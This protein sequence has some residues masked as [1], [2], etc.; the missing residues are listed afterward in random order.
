MSY[1]Q[2][3]YVRNRGMAPHIRNFGVRREGPT[4]SSGHSAAG[5]EQ[6]LPRIGSCCEPHSWSAHSGENT[7][8]LH[9][10]EYDP[11]TVHSVFYSLYG[12][13]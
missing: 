2:K 1:A 10:S 3:A 9:L 6:R 12:L 5:K 7:N 11:R 8:I 13:R 4:S